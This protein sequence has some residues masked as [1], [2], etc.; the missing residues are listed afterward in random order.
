MYEH[1]HIYTQRQIIQNTKY[2]CRSNISEC[3]KYD[4]FFE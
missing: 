3:F 2:E 4:A 1:A